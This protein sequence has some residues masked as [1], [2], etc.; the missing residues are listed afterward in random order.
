ME[1]KICVPDFL[2]RRLIHDH[3]HFLEHVVYQRVWEKMVLRYDRAHYTQ[4]QKVAKSI[5]ALCEVCQTCQRPLSRKTPIESTPIP[6]FPMV[7]VA[8][9]WFYL[10]TVEFWDV[11][12]IPLYCVTTDTWD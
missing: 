7:S 10:P 8:M 12:M 9:Y 11:Y 5:I 6:P 1:G 4:A 3:H 2:N